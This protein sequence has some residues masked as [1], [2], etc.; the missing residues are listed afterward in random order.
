MTLPNIGDRASGTK[1]KQVSN[2]AKLKKD[3][4]I[5]ESSDVEVDIVGPNKRRRLNKYL[6]LVNTAYENT[7]AILEDESSCF[8]EEEGNI[9]NYI[10][11]DTCYNNNNN[12]ED[13]DALEHKQHKFTLLDEDTDEEE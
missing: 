11:P 13:G 8:D 9:R 3:V 12:D 10:Y 5:I 6:N 2:N 1:P 7:L 4:I